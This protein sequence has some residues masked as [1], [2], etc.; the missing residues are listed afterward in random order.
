M[1]GR[2][3]RPAVCLCDVLAYHFRPQGLSQASTPNS[4]RRKTKSTLPQ[5]L[6]HN[7]QTSETRNEFAPDFGSLIVCWSSE[8]L[9][10]APNCRDGRMPG[11]KRGCLSGNFQ[12]VFYLPCRRGAAPVVS[13]IE[14][15]IAPAISPLSSSQ[16]SW[17][18]PIGEPEASARP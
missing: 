17:R 6:S 9:L 13:K 7:I 18:N 5:E 3:R 15:S 2:A 4:N 8:L 11:H 16:F 14:A 10:R 12:L 1:Q